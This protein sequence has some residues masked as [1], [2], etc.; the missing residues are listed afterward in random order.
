MLE[1]PVE[2]LRDHGAQQL[3]RLIGRGLEPLL[4]HVPRSCR[5]DPGVA[6]QDVCKRERGEQDHHMNHRGQVVSHT[7]TAHHQGQDLS[8]AQPCR[9]LPV[10][11]SSQGNEESDEQEDRDALV[12]QQS[13]GALR[14]FERERGM[15]FPGCLHR[16]RVRAAP[17]PGDAVPIIDGH[18]HVRGQGQRADCS[19][20]ICR[21][22]AGDF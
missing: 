4:P 17:Y 8:H 9:C 10:N 16:V 5:T 11:P 3:E 12:A 15:M 21:R 19:A 14:V 13:A 7:Q 1:L 22:L 20:N 18:V 6:D 2:R